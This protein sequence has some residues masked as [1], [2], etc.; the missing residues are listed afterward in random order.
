M[1]LILE[2]KIILEKCRIKNSSRII[3]TA[4]AIEWLREHPP[5]EGCSLIASLPDISE[6]QTMSLADWKSWFF[7]TAKLV[8]SKTSDDGVSIFYQSDI[9]YEGHWVDKA[10]IVQKAAE[11]L[12][13]ELLWHKIVC[14]NPAGIATFGRPSFSHMLCFSKKFRIHDLAKSTADV[15]PDIGEKTWQR[16]MGFNACM[17]IAKFIKEEVGSHTIIHPFCGEGSMVS[18]ANHIGLNAIGVEKSRKRA[19]KAQRIEV[20]LDGKSWNII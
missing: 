6:F 2:R 5:Q 13:H 11:E 3:H 14:R 20:A 16:G 10:Y 15:I 1:V 7:E 8:L 17:I 4:D 9:K 12:G 19:E 18:V